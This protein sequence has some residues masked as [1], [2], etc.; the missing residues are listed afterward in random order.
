[1]QLPLRDL[2]DRQIAQLHGAAQASLSGFVKATKQHGSLIQSWVRGAAV[3]ALDHYPKGD[4][5][6]RRHAS[7]M[8]YHCHRQGDVEHGHVHLFC[9]ATRSGRRLYLSQQSSRALPSHLLALGLD[10]RGLPISLFT[11]NRWVTDGHWFDAQTTLKLLQRFKMQGVKNHARSCDWASNFVRMYEPLI[12]KLL[13]K[14][15][16][17]LAR[18]GPLEEALDNQRIE[19]LS[20]IKLDWAADLA[21]LEQEMRRRGLK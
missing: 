13:H 21:K 18:A 11:V 8:F 9:H 3:T 7:Q 5:I 15:D 10:A 19:I 14:R 16:Q 4:V 17:R 6:D 20:S 1:M 12:E 2:S